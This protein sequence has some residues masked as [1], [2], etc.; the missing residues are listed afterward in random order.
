[1]VALPESA[2]VTNRSNCDHDIT[3]HSPNSSTGYV[4]LGGRWLSR[5]LLEEG[6]NGLLGASC[7]QTN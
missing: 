1:M 3:A 5:A 7:L 6:G 4:V 2:D